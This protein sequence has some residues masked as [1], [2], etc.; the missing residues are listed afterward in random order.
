M[1]PGD[2]GLLSS[3]EVFGEL[4]LQV[5]YFSVEESMLLLLEFYSSF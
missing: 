5:V 2:L 4:E 1:P 3:P